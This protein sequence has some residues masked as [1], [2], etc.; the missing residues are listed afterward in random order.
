[1]PVE[2][3]LESCLGQSL[4]AQRSKEAHNIDVALHLL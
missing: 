1:M 4:E 2:F 3:N